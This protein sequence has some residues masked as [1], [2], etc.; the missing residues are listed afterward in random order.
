VTGNIQETATIKLRH[1]GYRPEVFRVGAYGADS[2]DRN[3]LPPLAVERAYQLTG[4]RFSGEA[5][6][7]IGDTPADVICAQSVGARSIAVLTGWSER[8]ALEAAQPDYLLDDLTNPEQ[9]IRAITAPP[10]R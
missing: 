9:V 3:D 6:V 4:V 5:I 8:D 7:I 2:V 1:L 10:Q